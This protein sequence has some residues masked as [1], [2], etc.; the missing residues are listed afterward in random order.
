M[1]IFLQNCVLF[2]TVENNSYVI[3]LLNSA[4]HCMMMHG[5]ER[6]IHGFLCS[7][8][9]KVN[10]EFFNILLLINL[11]VLVNNEYDALALIFLH[12]IECILI[13][14]NHSNTIWM[15]VSFSQTDLSEKH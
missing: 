11:N 13:S 9:W 1:D 12:L 5:K 7:F 14:L 6:N 4:C 3:G 10:G 15:N 2:N 8:L